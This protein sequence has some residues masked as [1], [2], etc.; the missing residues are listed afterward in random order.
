MTEPFIDGSSRRSRSFAIVALAAVTFAGLT[1]CDKLKARDLLHQGTN[2]YAAGQTDAAVEDFKKAM[3]LDP[4][5]LTAQLYLATA[6]QGEYV[7]GA[8]SDQN[9]RVA[10]EALA[11]YKDVLTKDPNNTR[12][13]DGIGSLLCAMANHP[14]SADT[15]L[16]A[17]TYW[18]EHIKVAPDDPE[19]YYWVGFIDWSIAYSDN[20]KLRA[21][22]NKANPKKQIHDDQPLPPDLREKF[23][24]SDGATIDEG[25][26]YM[27]K[28]IQRR[29]D[30]DDAIAYLNLLDRQKADVVESADQRTALLNEADQLMDQVK[31]IKQKR[32]AAQPAH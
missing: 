2:A 3:D 10:T 29:Q 19:P 1:G 31:E 18:L 11:Q 17:K 4:N 27:K 9:T 14:F 12:A 22:Y 32:A 6:Y 16:Q 30:Y 26:D 15:F 20:A 21:D 25:I 13:M 23:A 28:A 8:T 7:A 5:L 24:A